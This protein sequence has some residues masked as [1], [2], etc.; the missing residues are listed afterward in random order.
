MHRSDDSCLGWWV[1]CGHFDIT[2][3]NYKEY[4]KDLKEMAKQIKSQN[5]GVLTAWNKYSGQ[6]VLDNKE[7]CNVLGI[8]WPSSKYQQ[9]YNQ[10][11]IKVKV[12]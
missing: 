10:N 4:Y 8:Q 1:K 2:Y 9:D 12:I 6:V 11:D 5:E 3:P 7:L